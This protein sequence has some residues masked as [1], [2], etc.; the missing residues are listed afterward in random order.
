[1]NLAPNLQSRNCDQTSTK[2]TRQNNLRYIKVIKPNVSHRNP[3]F[4]ALHLEL[5]FQL[6][7]EKS[8]D[9]NSSAYFLSS[10]WKKNRQITEYKSI[11]RCY[12]TSFT[13]LLLFIILGLLNW[14]TSLKKKVMMTTP[15][16]RRQSFPVQVLTVQTALLGCRV[17]VVDI[18]IN[19]SILNLL[20]LLRP[21]MAELE[22]P[23]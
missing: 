22:R 18:E 15:L 12:L 7:E 6:F 13:L 5:S 20:A 8:D 23:L 2:I 9:D 4:V 14:M 3:I 10:S 17:A 16:L 11:Y 19:K 1:M 21:P